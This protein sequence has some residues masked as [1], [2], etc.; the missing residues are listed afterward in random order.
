MISP[1]HKLGV[2]RIFLKICKSDRSRAI[3][4][5]FL[6]NQFSIIKS[7]YQEQQVVI[8]QGMGNDSI[9]KALFHKAFKI[10]KKDVTNA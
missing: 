3:K 7:F 4:T 10:V 6:H 9:L 2:S 8:C 1:L 5:P